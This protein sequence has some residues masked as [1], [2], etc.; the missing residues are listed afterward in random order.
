MDL[1]KDFVLPPA[2]IDNPIISEE[3]ASDKAYYAA[4]SSSPNPIED[5]HQVYADLSQVGGSQVLDNALAQYRVEQEETTKNIVTSIIEDPNLPIEQKKEVLNTYSIG[6]YISKDIRDRYIQRSASLDMG[7]SLSDTKAQDEVIKNLPKTLSEVDA[8]AHRQSIVEGEAH[9]SNYAKAFGITGTNLVTG[10]GAGLL[11]TLYSIYKMDAVAGKELFDKYAEEW[12]ILPKEQATAN[13]VDR[14]GSTLA[15]L[16]YP[17][18]KIKESTM[19]MTGSAGAGIVSGVVFDPIN[20]IPVGAATSLIKKGVKG[21]GPKVRSGSP[22]DTTV[23]TNPKM[24]SDL[25]LGALEDTTDTTARALG[26]NRAAIV[27]EFVL[28][29]VLSEVERNANPD[30]SAALDYLDADLE[31][32]F[33]GSRFDPNIQDVSQRQS[34]IDAVLGIINETRKPAYIQSQSI[35]NITDNVFEGRAVFAKDK[36][37]PYSSVEDAAEA[38]N[39]ILEA[40]K[41][42]P[43]EVASVSILD[44]TTGD[45]YTAESL[46][47][48]K[49]NQEAPHNYVVE[50]QW[51]R[52]YNDT[53][54]RLF[55]PDAVKTSVLGFDFSGLARTGAARWIFPHSTLPKWF[56]SSA[57]RQAER[58]AY[59]SGNLVDLIR[60]N[61]LKT[62][63]K[64]ELFALIRNSEELGIEHY[65]KKTLQGMFPDLGSAQ[66]DDLFTAHT[67]W[68]R[69]NH[70]NYE[71]ANFLHANELRRDGYTQGLYVDN[72]YIGPVNDKIKFKNAGE[73]PLKVWDYDLDL[74]IKF[75]WLDTKKD[76][77]YDIGGK[78]LVALKKPYVDKD[79]NIY[80]YALHGGERSKLDLLPS[81][82]LPRIPGYSPIKT[83]GHFF[84]RI[85]PTKLSI[86][87]WDV[88][89]KTR[90]ATHSRVVGAA[91]TEFEAKKL[92][93]HF[94]ATYPDHVVDYRPDR[95][96]DYGR[97]IDDMQAQGELLRNAMQRGERLQSINGPAPIEDRLI[98]LVNTTRALQRQN[99]MRVWE[100]ATKEAFVKDY[101]E[102][103]RNGEFPQS[104]SDIVPPPNMN[105]ETA[106]DFNNARRVWEYYAKI[107]SF[108]GLSD[109]IWKSSLHYVADILEKWKVPSNLVRDVANKGNLLF[110]VP[111]QIASTLFIH[112]NPV[113]Q[114]LVQPAQLLEMWA[115]NPLSA[116]QNMTNL[117]AVRVALL[118]DA[119]VMKGQSNLFKDLSKKMV[120]GMDKRE[121][122]LT[123]KAIKESGVMQ[124]VDLNMLVHGV[125]NDVNRGLLEGSW[126]K[127]YNDAV[128]VPK[129]GVQVAR[130]VGFDFAELNNRIGLWLQVKELWKQQNPGKNWNTPEAKEAI[131][132]EAFKISG[133]MNR[134]GSLPYQQGALSTLFQF[135][136]ISQ[137][138]LLNLIQDNATILTPN[139]R[140]RLT[141]ARASLWGIKYGLPGGALMYYYLDKSDDP[142]V[143]ENAE[144]LK[145]GLADRVGNYFLQAIAG[146]EES[147]VAF[148]KSMSPYGELTSGVPY[149][150]V[151][152]EMAKMFDDRPA[153]PRFPAIGAVTALGQAVDRFQSWFTTKE[154]TG[155]DWNKAVWEAAKV[156]SSF[157]NWSK[158][159]LM[160]STGDKITKNGNELGLRATAAEAYGQLLGFTTYREDD[161]WAMAGQIQD[162]KEMIKSMAGDIHQWMVTQKTEL[163]DDSWETNFGML[164]SF[165]SLLKNDDNWTD[166]DIREVVDQVVELDK[167]RYKDVNTS[168]L[169]GLLKA[170]TD[171]NDEQLKI[172]ERKLR[173]SADPKTK[174]LLDILDGKRKP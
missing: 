41:Q 56:E 168:I 158:A 75:Q 116:A 113:K 30:L 20:L 24:A 88:I 92:Q 74:P 29:K 130:S 3:A 162:R 52:E 155:K 6:G 174:E 37:Y 68:R 85:T 152:F 101:G 146:S 87:G 163:G 103:L 167:Q 165:M 84:V 83:E 129:A 48:A 58:A 72:K 38:Y 42:L 63:Y 19:R 51:K 121:F 53:N 33:K 62:P 144:I 78:K 97:I 170:R 106:K 61:I 71:V 125:F 145:R 122:D 173:L 142:V 143:Q 15:Y 96:E 149:I 117:A 102:F 16:G 150:D 45:R 5:Y 114:W 171:D 4:A 135:A 55:G 13:L 26:T 133:A 160:L 9:F 124:S 8:K 66:I 123:V 77:T 95:G 164:T 132:V 90:L 67:Y 49:L 18:Q 147:D 110:N 111:R 73:A 47:A 159:Q 108:E 44:R 154:I 126:E 93:E 60:K 131:S 50:M 115:I 139:Q 112:L 65:S 34:D 69:V 40:S 166:Q 35:I 91:K 107:K 156:A 86:N 27:N 31:A 138:L 81:K 153:G 12:S 109:H 21:S 157:S 82:V 10:M 17:A 70:Y 172:V 99:S 148:A 57:L 105:R 136:A 134:A 36:S 98:T 11:G 28:P 43:E 127:L 151:A 169:M 39:N 2:Q 59:V 76:A 54:L 25:A 7:S 119:P 104:L 94:Q 64:K 89:D 46:K 79:G 128:A 141:A 1:S 22:L 120:I 118:A 137:K 161:L 140:V 100:D 23:S 80:E 32:M 14:M